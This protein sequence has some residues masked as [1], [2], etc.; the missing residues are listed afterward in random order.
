MVHQEQELSQ[1]YQNEGAAR[2]AQGWAVDRILRRRPSY[3]QTAPFLYAVNKALF[4]SQKGS[5]SISRIQCSPPFN[6][7]DKL[8]GKETLKSWLSLQQINCHAERAQPNS[9]VSC[10][11]VHE[12]SAAETMEATAHARWI[13]TVKCYT[14]LNGTISGP[15]RAAPFCFRHF[16]SASLGA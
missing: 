8:V 3:A 12:M 1:T 13:S 6:Q 2:G 7:V 9:H 15:K 11:Y 5:W 4:T 16:V 14:F 10:C